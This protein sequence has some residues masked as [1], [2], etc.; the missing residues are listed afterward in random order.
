MTQTSAFYRTV[1]AVGRVFLDIEAG[2]MAL[3]A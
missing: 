1:G 3:A 2:A